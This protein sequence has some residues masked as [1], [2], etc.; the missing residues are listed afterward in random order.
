MKFFGYLLFALGLVIGGV[1]LN[2]DTTVEAGG[3]TIGSGDYAVTVP[4]SRIQNIGLLEDRRMMF[5]G[6]GLSLLL[7]SIFVGFGSLATRVP[8]A[9]TAVAAASSTLQPELLQAFIQGSVISPHDVEILAKQ[10]GEQASIVAA[11][12]RMNGN[13]LLHVA[14]S[15]GLTSAASL[16]LS[17][18]A[19][20]G[21][22]NGNGL[23]PFQLASN[24]ELGTMLRAE[25]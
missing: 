3:Q 7:G 19:D 15:Y 4:Q 16:L 8:A 20:R 14:A 1:A 24:D 23:R 25:S 12:S 2:M 6:A 21:N 17:A 10:A 5:Y 11:K 9:T 18:G 22:V 13:S